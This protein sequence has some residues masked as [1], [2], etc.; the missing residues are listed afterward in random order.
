MT[1][2]GE[3]YSCQNKTVGLIITIFYKSMYIEIE[4]RN[5]YT[6]HNKIHLN[7]YYFIMVCHL[8]I[9]NRMRRRMIKCNN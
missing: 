7:Y 9:R 5:N 2:V 3:L 8:Y 1:G 6:T 4:C